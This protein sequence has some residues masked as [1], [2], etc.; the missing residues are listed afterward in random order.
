MKNLKK[1]SR[2]N[3]KNV[4]G[5]FKDFCTPGPADICGQYGLS[6]GVNM[7][8]QNGHVISTNMACL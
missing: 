7:T 2:E 3:L 1:L 8:W 5:G 4:S 6:C